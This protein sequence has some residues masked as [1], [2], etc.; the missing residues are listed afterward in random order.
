MTGVSMWACT[1]LHGDCVEEFSLI[2]HN[3]HNYLYHYDMD[4]NRLVPKF[5]TRNYEDVLAAI[6]V[7]DLP[8]PYALRELPYGGGGDDHSTRRVIVDK[9][10][11]RGCDFEGFI[12]PEGILLNHYDMLMTMSR[13]Y[14][15]LVDFGSEIL[16]RI[17]KIDRTTLTGEQ[18]ARLVKLEA[19]IGV[20]DGDDDCSLLFRGKFIR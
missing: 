3:T 4:N 12:T 10:T 14:F 15:H 1:N 13:G 11:L 17:K 5:T 19:L 16:E 18:R 7:Y 8:Q 20:G 6:N 2:S 9:A